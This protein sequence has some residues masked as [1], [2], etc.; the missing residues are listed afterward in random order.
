MKIKSPGFMISPSALVEEQGKTYVF[1]YDQG[2]ARKTEVKTE[3]ESGNVVIHRG[4]NEGDQ[5]LLAG[6]LLTD[7][8]EVKTIDEMTAGQDGNE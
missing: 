5:V 2:I 7:G 8:Q 4:V 1:V 3:R 6:S